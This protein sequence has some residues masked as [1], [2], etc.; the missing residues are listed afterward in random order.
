MS[1]ERRSSNRPPEK[2]A[3]T[4]V[5]LD[6]RGLPPPEPMVLTLERLEA[7]QDDE[8]LVHVNSRE[9]IYLLPILTERGYR[10]VVEQ[11]APGLFHVRIW[12]GRT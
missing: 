4:E 5:Y 12:R 1:D 8:E 3:R 11:R 9:P 7:L 10:Y 2:A 6:V